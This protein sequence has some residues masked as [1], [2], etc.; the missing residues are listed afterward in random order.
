M[1]NDTFSTEERAAIKE[2]A[3]ELKAQAKNAD[4]EKDVL[5]KI[6]ALTQPD[7]G[8][9]ERIHELVKQHAPSLTFKSW[10]GMPGYAK[11]GKVLVF[12]QGA[13]KFGTRYP[14]LGFNDNAQ[15]DDG[16]LW[17]VAFAIAKLGAAE[18]KKIAALLK[19]AAR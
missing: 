10:Y 4:A 15:L 17:P 3:K 12:F 16:D 18:E 9:A 11:D 2:R 6:A 8:K 19:K 13:D 14:T 7:R 5:D 1:A